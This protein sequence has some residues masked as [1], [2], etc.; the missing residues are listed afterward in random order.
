MSRPDRTVLMTGASGFVGGAILRELLGAGFRVRALARDPERARAVEPRAEWLAYALPEAPPAA[1]FADDPVALVH[2]A[3]RTD[4]PAEA[5]RAANVAGARRLH[6]A[7]RAGASGPLI[8][9]SSQAAHAEALSAY[10]RGKREAEGLLDPARDA[11][12]RPALVVGA[13]GIVGRIADSLR[14]VPVVPVFFG[15]PPLQVVGADEVAGAARAVIERGLSGRF[16]LAHPQ[17][18]RFRELHR[19]LGRTVGRRVLCVPLPGRLALAALALLE[20]RVPL[21]VGRESL[22]GLRR[23]RV[24]DPGESWARLG[25]QPRSP[26]ELLGGLSFR[27]PAARPS[28][29]APSASA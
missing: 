20:G 14:R 27:A 18:L 4:G 8:F 11:I 26:A 9:I 1:A 28:R 15:D 16:E 3:W 29:R 5:A 10:G 25:I 22:L 6:D 21:P 17:A 12:L 23:A 13:G 2:A 19:A 24:C 7:W